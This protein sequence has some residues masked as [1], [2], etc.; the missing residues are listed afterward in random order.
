MEDVDMSSLEFNPSPDEVLHY[1]S[2]KLIKH[3][4]VYSKINYKFNIQ[5]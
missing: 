2:N 5:I 4:I 3:T 1:N